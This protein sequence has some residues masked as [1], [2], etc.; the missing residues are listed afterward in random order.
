MA[1]TDIRNEN[2]AA[3]S[4]STPNQSAATTV[5]PER[6]MPGKSANAWATPMSTATP[7]PRAHE[8]GAGAR[9]I[10]ARALHSTPPV[11]RNAT[12]AA[13]GVSNAAST[14]SPRRK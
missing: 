3:S 11:T 7:G 9:R 6:E 10:A 8:N 1:G 14:T 2:S 13:A 5:D 4:D 12:P